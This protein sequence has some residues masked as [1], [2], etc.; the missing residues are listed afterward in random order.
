MASEIEQDTTDRAR[1]QDSAEPLHIT[2]RAPRGGPLRLVIGVLF[3]LLLTMLVALGASRLFNWSPFGSTDR[4]RSG[5]AVLT[6]LR[7]L[8]EYHASSGSYQILIDLE[9][10]QK[11]VPDIIKGRR[12][13]FLAIG[14]V[15]SY[16]DFG[17][18][19]DKAVSVSADRRSVTITLPHA[20]LGRPTIDTTQSRILDRNLGLVDRLGNI[21]GNGTNPQDQQIYQLAERKLAAAATQGGLVARAEANTKTTLDRL[22][23]ALG[24]TDVTVTFV[25]PTGT[26]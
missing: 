8:S 15:D 5:P 9:Q 6:A 13:L 2:V 14:S 16:V 21:F 3:A 17:K 25:G 1:G 18:L 11:Y 22:I 10:D 23:K 26:P 12:T 24:F 7:D 20:Q 4:D 19:D